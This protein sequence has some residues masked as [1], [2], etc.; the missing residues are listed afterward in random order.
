VAVLPMFPLGTVLFPGALL[1]LHVFEP[2]YRRLVEDCLLNRPEFGVVLIDRGHE[3]GGGDVRRDVGT[4]A[5]LLEVGQLP[6]GRYLLQTAGVR[7]IRV[8]EWLADDPYPRAEVVDWEDE[9]ADLAST[10]HVDDVLNQLRRVRALA[11][12]LAEPAGPI[13]VEIAPD[14]VLASYHLAALSPVGPEDDYRL[15]ARPGPV[16]RLTLLGELLAD[17]EVVLQLRLSGGH[18]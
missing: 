13:D 10:A 14:P 9:D 6:D 12:E 8:V 3:V 4:V 5:Q 17:A 1:P 18:A 11:S 7:R 15:L 16:E 2:R